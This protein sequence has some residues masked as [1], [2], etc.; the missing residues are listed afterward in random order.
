MQQA[1]AENIRRGMEAQ[2][3]LW[4][5]NA[6]RNALWKWNKSSFRLA[7]VKIKE[8]E[9][10]LMDLQLGINTCKSRRESFESQLRMQRRRM[11]SI[12]HPKARELWIA[13]GDR[14]TKYFHTSVLMRRREN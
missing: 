5:L 9:L 14:N 3:L 4:K 11:E 8:L 13:D 1:W 12:Y 6:T 7:Y 2:K 10:E